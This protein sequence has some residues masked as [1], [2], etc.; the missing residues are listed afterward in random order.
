[1]KDVRI[2]AVAAIL[3]LASF[4]LHADE[5]IEWKPGKLD[6]DYTKPQPKQEPIYKPEIE[7]AE[8]KPDVSVS[9]ITIPDSQGRPARGGSITIRR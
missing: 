4:G 1:M 9:P 3:G 7:K 8:P 5:K 6:I 2:V